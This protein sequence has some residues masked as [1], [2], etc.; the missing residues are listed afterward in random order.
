VQHGDNHKILNGG[1]VVMTAGAV[2]PAW[3]H[4]LVTAEQTDS[5]SEEQFYWRV[6]QALT[7]VPIVYT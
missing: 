1:G 6:E 7:G 2:A 4:E 3:M 5:W